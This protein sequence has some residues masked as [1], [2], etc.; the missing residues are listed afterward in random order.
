MIQQSA[1]QPELCEWF[2][3]LVSRSENLPGFQ[4]ELKRVAAKEV[5]VL[6]M[7]QGQK[8]SRLVAWRF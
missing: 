5:R 4:R 6:P 8:R 3:C 2:T 7:A 1:R